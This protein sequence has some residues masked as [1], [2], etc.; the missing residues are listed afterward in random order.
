MIMTNNYSTE[1]QTVFTIIP[2]EVTKVSDSDTCQFDVSKE[3]KETKIDKSPSKTLLNA[4]STL[5]DCK[6]EVSRNN[7]SFFS[8]GKDH[9]RTFYEI[10]SYTAESHMWSLNVMTSS[11]H[12]QSLWPPQWEQISLTAGQ[13][14]C[15]PASP[16]CGGQRGRTAPSASA[17]RS[18]RSDV[19]WCHRPAGLRLLPCS[20]WEEDSHIRV[21]SLSV[22]HVKGQSWRRK[23]EVVVNLYLLSHHF[24][25]SV[26]RNMLELIC[27]SLFK[28]TLTCRSFYIFCLM[29]SNYGRRIGP[30]EKCQNPEKNVRVLK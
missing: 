17:P 2:A 30:L 26:A 9:Q 3:K 21:C 7:R 24:H 1:P 4:A 11:F 18:H 13:S 20:T 15:P 25:C 12:L 16:R 29:S 8:R 23:E 14:C 6:A 22:L 27:M 28:Q 19:W 5:V 10:E